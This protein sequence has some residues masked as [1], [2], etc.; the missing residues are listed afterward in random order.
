MNRRW[1]I[2]LREGDH[3]LGLRPHRQHRLLYPQL[4]DTAIGDRGHREYRLRWIADH[5][6]ASMV[7]LPEKVEMYSAFETIFAYHHTHA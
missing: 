4:V 7:V 1:K 3:V 5:P 2:P 6:M